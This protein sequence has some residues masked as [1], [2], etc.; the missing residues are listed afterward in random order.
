MV[1][2]FSFLA[3]LFAF[4]TVNE[5]FLDKRRLL[6]ARLKGLTVTETKIPT[7]GTDHKKLELGWLRSFITSFGMA[8]GPMKRLD[9]NLSRADILLKAEEFFLLL[10]SAML[11]T[12]GLGYLATNRISVAVVGALAGF[13]FPNVFLRRAQ[14][15]RLHA[16]N[17]QIADALLVMAN[18]LRAGFGFLQAMEVVR[19]EMPPPISKE[20]G[21][22]LAEMNLGI[23]TEEALGNLARRIKSDDL[24]LV[25]TA[26]IIQRT[27][28]GNL[29]TILDT[30]AETIRERVRIKGE[31][32]S[33]TAQGRISGMI[34]GFLPVG[35]ALLL[36]LISPKYMSTLFSTSMGLTL[37]IVAG[38]AEA[39]GALAIK[40]IISIKV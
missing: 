17:A 40:R 6:E 21:Q 29:A 39:I 35:L 3:V 24:D 10:V 23:S 37:V 11:L 9:E 14:A 4:L 34:V 28:G 31:I 30:I 36:F 20:F 38:V 32:R 15:R 33:L 22:A 13:A 5:Y 7:K 2:A 25:V 16:F 26:V 27:V 12:G 19:R 8:R 1:V 18:T